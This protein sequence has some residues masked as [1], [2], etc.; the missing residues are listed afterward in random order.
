MPPMTDKASLRGVAAE[1]EPATEA[2]NRAVTALLSAEIGGAETACIYLPMPGELDV[3]SV[4][5][6]DLGI[7]WHTTRTERGRDLT[8]HP[9][10]SEMETH[11]FGF[12]QP[13]ATAQLVSPR[14]IDVWIVPGAAFD[15][16]GNRL[17][18]GRGYYDR[19]LSNARSDA[20]FIAVTLERRIFDQ[21]PAL[22]HDIAMHR[23]VTEKRVIRP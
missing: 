3:T 14:S 7:S 8:V 23:V 18:H 21:I 11:V 13:V 16:T 10:D 15:V 9:I 4:M 17:G 2:E 5:S 12:R 19:L 20:I 22:P 6:R 1:L